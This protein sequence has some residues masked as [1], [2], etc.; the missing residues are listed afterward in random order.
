MAEKTRVPP[1]K[2]IKNNLPFSALVSKLVENKVKEKAFIDEAGSYNVMTQ[3]ASLKAIS[4]DVQESSKNTESIIS[5]F[6][7]M[8][9]AMQILISTII[10]PKDMTGDELIYKVKNEFL[11]PEIT[12]KLIGIVKEHIENYYKIREDLPEALKQILFI[13]GAYAVCVIPESELDV[14]INSQAEL[15]TESF[16]NKNLMDK[17]NNFYSMGYLGIPKK[18]NKNM[19]FESLNVKPTNKNIPE[20]PLLTFSEEKIN[21][22]AKSIT[23]RVIHNVDIVAESNEKE[24]ITKEVEKY[25]YEFTKKIFKS[26]E[27]VT[28]NDNPDI[29]KLGEFAK[30]NLYDRSKKLIRSKYKVKY[31]NEDIRGVP[32]TYDISK[33][34]DALY[35]TPNSKIS[36]F[37]SLSLLQPL[38]KNIGRPLMMKLPTESIIPVHTPGNPNQHIGYF[39]L[40]DQHGSPL[41]MVEKITALTELDEGLMQPDTSMNSILVQ[42]AQDNIRGKNI[43]G[44]SI[45]NALP[46]YIN[47]IEQELLA[48]LEAGIYGKNVEISN[49]NEIYKIMLSRTLKNQMTKIVYM[50]AEMVEYMRY[51]IH[52]NG[53]GKALTENLRILLSIRA[54]MLFSRLMASVKNSIGITEINL[55]LDERDPDPLKTI[56]IVK[57]EILRARQQNFP[58]GIST[59]MDLA[60]WVQRSGL[61]FTFEGHPR[62]PDVKLEYNQHGA[63]NI[64]PDESLDEDLRKRTIMAYGLAPET[65]DNGFSPDF[66]TTVVANNILL[67]KRVILIQ[68][69]ILGHLKNLISKIILSDAVIYED[70][71][72]IVKKDLSTIK[73]IIKSKEI[74]KIP[75]DTLIEFV[76]NEF[77]E[78]L[79][80]ELPLPETTTITNQMESFD[81]YSEFLDKALDAWVNQDM[82]DSNLVGPLSEK[83]N[84]VKAVLKSY[85]IRKWL[86]ENGVMEE[87]SEIEKDIDATNVFEV[88]KE[89]LN[90]LVVSSTKFITG[91]QDMVKAVGDDFNNYKISPDGGMGDTTSGGGDD[92]FG[93]FDDDLGE[94]DNDE[95]AVTTDEVQTEIEDKTDEETEGKSEQNEE[96]E[97]T[98]E[99]ETPSI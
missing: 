11:T 47:L 32:D 16:K 6:P 27:F 9:L 37:M 12:G 65:I 8:E 51:K 42:R 80:V 70:L 87:L 22:L 28:I 88:Q 18:E 49:V 36:P 72:K 96:A 90:K 82:F 81:K 33:L 20:A 84:S 40:V 73:E 74:N 69:T 35:K 45:D 31:A 26:L 50:P 67:S 39:V 29:L 21:T 97:N 17:N 68:K 58:I 54:M 63:S 62:I 95:N 92:D 59:P 93:G 89:F 23:D 66:A 3:T 71:A 79:E 91:M 98:E 30:Y 19:S 15:S 44:M 86:V 48:R 55:K 64:M 52:P 76:I 78:V 83:A 7:D 57:N 38:R 34:R 25:T 14:I 77:V 41:H 46:I 53:V 5:L 24:M 61:E 60:D 85:Y 99:A 4:K 94:T 10:S 43:K 1:A 2:F 75:D 13:S 56:E